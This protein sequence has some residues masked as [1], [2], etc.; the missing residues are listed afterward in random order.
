[1]ELTNELGKNYVSRSQSYMISRK[2]QTT[3]SNQTIT[4][5]IIHGYTFNIYTIH[6]RKGEVELLLEREKVRLEKCCQNLINSVL[7]IS[8]EFGDIC[9]ISGLN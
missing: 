1:M 9:F 7:L 4:K 5:I 2:Y 8:Y 3:L 6:C